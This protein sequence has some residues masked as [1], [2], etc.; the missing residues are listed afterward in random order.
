[1]IR[2]DDPRLSAYAL[3]ELPAEATAEVER[4][5]EG[6]PEAVAAVEDLRAMAGTLAAAFATEPAVALTE[7]Q[8]AA[9]VEAAAQ[10]TEARAPTLAIV[11]ARRREAR[12]WYAWTLAAAA[13]A[14]GILVIGGPRA[15]R[16]SRARRPRG[17]SARR[18][19]TQRVAEVVGFA[20]HP[21]RAIG[22]QGPPT[23]APDDPKRAL[24]VTSTTAEAARDVPMRRPATSRGHLRARRVEA[25]RPCAP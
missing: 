12:P 20:S 13:A 6:D 14:A 10:P 22:R 7:T 4:L 9:V 24:E 5:L 18:S 23:P 21:E 2:I 25:C 3:G 15:A 1:M 19:T 11:G 16:G 17:R 8:R